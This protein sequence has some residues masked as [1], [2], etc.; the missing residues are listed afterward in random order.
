MMAR[1]RLKL[2]DAVLPVKGK[3]EV[4]HPSR[5]CYPLAFPHEAFAEIMDIVGNE[6]WFDRKADLGRAI[7]ELQGRTMAT[8][9]GVPD[10]PKWVGEA[11]DALQLATNMRLLDNKLRTCLQ[12]LKAPATVTGANVRLLDLNEMIVLVECAIR[13]TRLLIGQATQAPLRPMQT[14]AP[15]IPLPRL[16]PAMEIQSRAEMS[17]DAC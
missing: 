15:S 5:P 11:S 3:D 7:W 2:K 9:F 4:N 6:R 14:V 12:V 1:V 10:D 13:I 17:P 8:V 16:N